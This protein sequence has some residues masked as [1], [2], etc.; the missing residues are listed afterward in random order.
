[1]RFAFVPHCTI[2][3]LCKSSKKVDKKLSYSRDTCSAVQGYSRPLILIPIE[4]PH[5]TSY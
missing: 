5:T 3:K 4:S 2:A 1:V